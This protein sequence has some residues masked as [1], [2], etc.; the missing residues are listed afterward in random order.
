MATTWP[1]APRNGRA[2]PAGSRG[3]RMPNISGR[4]NGITVVAL[5]PAITIDEKM[6]SHIFRDADGHFREDNEANRQILINVS[7]QPSNYLG[8]DRAGNLWYAENLVDGTQVWVRVRGGKIV[9]GEINL[10]PRNSRDDHDEKKALVSRA[11]ISSNVCFS[12]S[13]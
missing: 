10:T 5:M 12:R 9:N 2:T 11:G 1:G 7:I 6:V 3:P 13:L 4:H 8:T